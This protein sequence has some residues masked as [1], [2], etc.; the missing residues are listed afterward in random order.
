MD[1]IIATSGEV[2]DREIIDSTFLPVDILLSET[3][4]GNSSRAWFDLILTDFRLTRGDG[5]N[6]EIQIENWQRNM[7]RV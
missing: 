5:A 2:L 6:I 3:L 7:K 1:A 4:S